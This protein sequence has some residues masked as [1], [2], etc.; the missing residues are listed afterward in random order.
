MEGGAVGTGGPW[1][2]LNQSSGRADLHDSTR[3]RVKPE[4]TERHEREVILA[5]I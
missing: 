2:F 3:T 4:G 5:K 1:H